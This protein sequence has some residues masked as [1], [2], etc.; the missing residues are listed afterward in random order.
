[1]E[2]TH[3]K[4]ITIV[5][6]IYDVGALGRDRNRIRIVRIKPWGRYF[7]QVTSIDTSKLDNIEWHRLDR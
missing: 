3:D 5:E 4:K 7:N 1:L 2:N 6:Q